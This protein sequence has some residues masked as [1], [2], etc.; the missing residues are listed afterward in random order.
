MMSFWDPILKS[1]AE[2]GI[3]KKFLNKSLFHKSEKFHRVFTRSA[4]LQK[5]EGRNNRVNAS[6]GLV[7]EIMYVL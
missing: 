5:I 7:N 2:N 3:S 1:P 6:T 4:T